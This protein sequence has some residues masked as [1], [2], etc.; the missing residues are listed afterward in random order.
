MYCRQVVL[1]LL[2][3]FV[4]FNV[5]AGNIGNKFSVD[6]NTCVLTVVGGLDFETRSRYDV[7]IEAA[8]LD[9]SAPRSVSEVF[10]IEVEDVNERPVSSFPANRFV[11]TS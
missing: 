9:S 2:L 10:P 3:I 5:S 1:K 8:D 11:N 6:N 4:S 7:T